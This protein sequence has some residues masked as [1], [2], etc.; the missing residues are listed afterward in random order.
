LA[1][2]NSTDKSQ[3]DFWENERF[4]FLDGKLLDIACGVTSRLVEV[5]LWESYKTF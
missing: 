5:H 1:N 2:L 4:T 3:V